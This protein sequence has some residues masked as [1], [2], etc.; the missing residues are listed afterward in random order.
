LTLPWGHDDDSPVADI[1]LADPQLAHHC[2]GIVIRGSP[3]QVV[4]DQD[5]HLNA[6]VLGKVI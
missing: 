4:D 6:A 5:G 2:P 3:F 1:E